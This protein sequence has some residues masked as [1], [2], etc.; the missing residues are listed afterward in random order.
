MQFNPR[1]FV[2]LLALGALGFLIYWFA[3][4][5][6]AGDWFKVQ[7]VYDGDTFKLVDGTKIRLL[8]ID[9]PET[10]KELVLEEPYALE[11]KQ[12]LERLVHGKKVRLEYDVQAYDQYGRDLCYV[13][14]E[15]SVFVNA[16]M[17]RAG[18]ARSLVIAP[19]F[20]HRSKMKEAREE[21]KKERKGIWQGTLPHLGL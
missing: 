8:G 9:A 20:K 12:Y 14:T 3:P 1:T 13:Y 5:K 17:L 2:Y 19:N 18:M 7:Y 15:D 16:E 10:E 11:S 6:D 4:R 21:A